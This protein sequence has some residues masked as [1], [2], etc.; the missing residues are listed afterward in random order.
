MIIPRLTG[1]VYIGASLLLATT[2]QAQGYAEGIGLSYE[3]L[4]L[5]LTT[6]PPSTFRAD[7]YRANVIVPFQLGKDS[8]HAVLA[9]AS[10]EHLRFSGQRPGFPVASVTGLLPMV[11]YRHRLTPQLELTALALPALNSDLRDVHAGDVI[12]GGIVRAGY[13]VNAH[14]AYRLTLGYRQQFFGPQYLVLLGL[15]WRIGQR[16]RAFGDL[17]TTFTLSYAATPRLTA[18]FNLNGAN[19]AYRLQEQDKYF[20]YMQGHYGLFAEAY[21][22]SHWAL[23]ATA[24]YAVARRIDVFS[25][26]DQVRATIDF[27][28]LGNEPVAVNPYIEKGPAFKVALSYRVATP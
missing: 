5:K 8:S 13:R 23:R 18:G 4:P 26:N 22:S 21:V 15:D 12:W 28:R 2:S 14:R 19:T 1:L 25:K 27:I 6:E 24:A 16:W 9:G 17:P 3:A 20:H 7:V 11:G 10:L